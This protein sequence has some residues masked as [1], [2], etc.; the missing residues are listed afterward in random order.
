MRNQVP[1][2][3]VVLAL[4]GMAVAQESVQAELE[5]LKKRVAELEDA[6]AE[7]EDGVSGRAL[8]QAFSARSLD[9]GGHL[10]SLFASVHGA[11]ATAT[12]HVVSLAELY[13]KARIDDH[14]S[15]F[16][17]PGFYSFNGGLLDNPATPATPGDPT[18]SRDLDT[19]RV[20]LSRLVTEWRHS[21]ALSVRGGI[22]GSPHGVTN[23]EYFLPSRI[24]GQ[25][26][27]HTRYFLQNT[28]YPQT[29]QGVSVSGKQAH[30]QNWLEY[31]AYFGVEP[32]S[33]DDGIGGARVGYHVAELGLTLAVDHG[34]GTRES[35]D[36]P[37]TNF[38]YLQAPFAGVFNAGRDYRFAGIDV[39]LRKGDLLARAELYYSA[40][41]GFEDQRAVSVEG[42]WFF[43]TQWSASYRFDFYD[44]G[45]DFSV[46]AAGVVELGTSTE[47][48]VG[49]SF[50]PND[51]VRLRLDWHHNNLPSS[52]DVVDYVN[53]SWSISF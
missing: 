48:V 37:T 20:F 32:D 52:D 28:L 8:V 13:L 50:N 51:Y 47:H 45:E 46:F 35:D 40:E 36:D 18:F 43:A 15:A 29:V 3:G 24:V 10:T 44:R 1:I 23:R 39:D 9:F 2:V 49:L 11:S 4:T 38:G 7:H 14:W 19:Q 27:L 21:D 16:A 41:D 22:V 17:T 31:D 42:T 33:A 26:N 5:A 53:V 6:Q 34:R 25:S 12:G 30:G